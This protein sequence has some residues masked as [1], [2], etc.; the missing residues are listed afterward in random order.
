MAQKRKSRKR[1]LPLRFWIISSLILISIG[2]GIVK[3][4]DFIKPIL[5]FEDIKLKK[6]N[7]INIDSD[8]EN[9]K[10]K[11]K[12]I[13]GNII[14]SQG[15]TV[16]SFDEDGK[17]LWEKDLS[18][19]EPYFG[20]SADRIIIGDLSK[21]YIFYLDKEGNTVKDILLEEPI[22]TLEITANGYTLAVLENSNKINVYNNDGEE[23]G[24]FEVP[25]GE[26][27]AASLEDED[28]VLVLSIIDTE[29]ERF[30]SN[31]IFYDIEGKVLAGKKH[32][33]KIIYKLQFIN[34][35]EVMAMG[36]N[37][38]LLF[39]KSN[40]IIW[41]KKIDDKINKIDFNNEGLAVVNL[42]KEK[43][44]LVDTKNR[45]TI[46]TVD[47]EGEMLSQTPIP[48]DIEGIDIYNNSILGFSTRTLFL[49]DDKRNIAIEKKL[50]KDIKEVWWITESNIGVVYKDEIEIIKMTP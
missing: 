29:D 18:I 15:N 47:K 25:K 34:G 4:V 21:G 49:L 20:G 26:I 31:I 13:G 1:R 42:I 22:Y 24:S 23:T 44:I 3:L 43:G 41:K 40:E 2:F 16:L 28:K 33:N 50:N 19:S 27:I 38:I 45:T 12:S 30:Y 36:Y 39:N 9:V 14:L 6:I 17:V 5:G 46:A 37:N 8:L 48:E 32:D 35:D 11:A 10:V 7:Q